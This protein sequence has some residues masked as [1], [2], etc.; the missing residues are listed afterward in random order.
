MKEEMEKTQASDAQEEAAAASGFAELKAAKSKEI[1]VA[2][3]A[4][5]TKTAQSG[6][7]AVLVAQA[8]SALGDSEAELADTQKYIAALKISCEEQQKA[9]TARQAARAEEVSA[10]SEAISILNDD[11]ALDVF[12]KALPNSFVS[13]GTR[14]MDFLQ[15]RRTV[16]PLQKA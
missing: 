2:S 5:E 12:K 6:E 15:S 13:M 7:L 3:A 4:I 8:K 10:I 9:W 16:S 14:R 11:D 1:E